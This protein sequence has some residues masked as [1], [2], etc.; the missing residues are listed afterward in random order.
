M[1]GKNNFHDCSCPQREIIVVPMNLN[2][3]PITCKEPSNTEVGSD[4]LS[5]YKLLFFTSQNIFN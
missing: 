4:L 5:Q 2:A 1:Y 3:V